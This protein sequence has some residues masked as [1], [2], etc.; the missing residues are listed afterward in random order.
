MRLATRINY[1]GDFAAAVERVVALE[2][3]G[4]DVVWVPEVY[5]FDAATQLGY[6]AAKTSRVHL[7]SGILPIYS[8]TPALI[9]MTAAGLDD[10]SGG[11]AILGLGASGPQVIEGWHGVAFD[12]PLR[13]T[14]EII[15][16]CRAI[17]RREYVSYEGQCYVLPLPPD[18]G[19]GL[20]KPLK[21]VTHP[22]RERIPVYLASL[23]PRS[24]ELAAELAEGWLPIFYVPEKAD[25]VWGAALRAGRAKR[26]PDLG[27]MEIAAGGPLAIG[28]G[29]EH[30]RDRHRPQLA[31]YI[32]GMG[33]RGKNFY[34]DLVCQYGY[35]D[36]AQEIQD[37]YLG[38]KKEQAMAAVPSELI[39][40]LSLVGSADFVRERIAAL[41][42]SGV[43]VLDVQ[44][45]G[46]DPVRD[47]ATVKEWIE[48]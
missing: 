21:M 3:V 17:W 48:A 46:P 9:A 31:L 13:R 37:L 24:V 10:L 28:D 40:A 11:R 47:V 15:D 2:A 32:G 6:L 33:A 19:T 22:R 36:A 16:I 44:P 42:A 8:R 5:G 1:A 26:P 27:P 38:G 29:L 30:L 20:G 45:I 34:N 23:T 7:A 39:D 12:R 41:K 25:V 18:Q 35:A 14:R 43:T 4:L